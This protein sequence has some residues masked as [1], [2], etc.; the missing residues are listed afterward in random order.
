M[1]VYNKLDKAFGPVGSA[2]CILLFIAGIVVVFNSL[3]GLFF[4]LVGSFVGFTSTCTMIDIEGKRLKFCNKLFGVINM[5]KWISIQSDMKLGLIHSNR[6]DRAYSQ[7]NRSFD[8]SKKDIR[9]CL[10]GA[11]SKRIMPIKRF[12]TLDA[13]KL[14][15]EEL[16]KQLGLC[17]VSQ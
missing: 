5:G 3:T 12:E 11:D 2:A 1:I 10:F 9:L 13:A 6:V 7:S 17:L 15:L 4:L 16:R 14:E 8:V